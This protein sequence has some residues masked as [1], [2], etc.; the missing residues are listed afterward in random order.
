[1]LRKNELVSEVKKVLQENKFALGRGDRGI[2]DDV[3]TAIVRR[4]LE[5]QHKD[6]NVD[7]WKGEVDR[8][9][10]SFTQEEI[11]RAKDWY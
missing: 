3:A 9:G 2:F 5:L 7:S 8:Q 11:N 10:G 4:V 6:T 1:M